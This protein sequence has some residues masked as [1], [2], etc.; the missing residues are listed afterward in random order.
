MKLTSVIMPD[1]HSFDQSDWE[2]Y[3]QDCETKEG[4]N[5]RKFIELECE[6]QVGRHTFKAGDF[7]IGYPDGN[8]A[9]YRRSEFKRLYKIKG[10]TWEKY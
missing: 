8:F 7:L 2:V 4:S 9:V 3:S 6:V 10:G 5:K 1:G